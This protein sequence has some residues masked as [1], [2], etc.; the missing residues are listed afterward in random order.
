MRTQSTIKAEINRVL[1]SGRRINKLQNEG[2]EGYD[3]T[4][5]AKLDALAKELTDSIMFYDWTKE[6]TVSRR[7][8]WNSEAKKAGATIIK[9]QY[10]LGFKASD[11]VAAV[12]YHK[13]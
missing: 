7:M 11:L 10:S 6:V 5:N 9:I 2:G 8:A 4:D 1:A 3:H 12:K 13:L